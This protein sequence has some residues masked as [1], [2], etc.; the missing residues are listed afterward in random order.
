MTLSPKQKLTSQIPRRSTVMMV[1]ENHVKSKPSY[2]ELKRRVFSISLL[3]SVTYKRRFV[4]EE[5]TIVVYE[6]WLPLG[7]FYPFVFIVSP[8]SPSLFP[9]LLHLSLL[10]PYLISLPLCRLFP[11]HVRS[12]PRK[13]RFSEAIRE[14][15]FFLL[16][17]VLSS[18]ILLVN[19][20]PKD[21]S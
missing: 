7:S 12:L 3:I 20:S 5:K 6:I 15:R 9:H 8:V 2:A 13:V 10:S 16:S 1:Q 14:H 18:I 19:S 21:H 17:Q 11:L 4:R